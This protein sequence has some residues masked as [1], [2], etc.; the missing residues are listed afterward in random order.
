MQMTGAQ[1]LM[2]S[3]IDQGVEVVFGY[4][5][6]QAIIIFD[7]LYEMRD[8]IRHVLVS[9]EQGGAHTADGY[10]RSTGKPG[11]MIATSGPG[12]TNLVT[13]IA[14]AYHDSI[15]L[16]AITG[17]VPR[18][19]IGLTSFQEVD[20]VSITRPIVKRNYF[21]EDIAT[22][23]DTVREAFEIANSGR[24]GPVLIDVP[25]DITAMKA[26]YV[27]APR[28]SVRP[29][30]SPPEETIRR[31]ARQIA[32]AKR[33]VIYCGGGVTF[34]DSAEALTAFAEKI[35]APVCMSM[36]GLTSLP[37]G[38]P[39]NMGLVGMH[40]TLTANM[41]VGKCDLL[42]AVGARFSDR[43]AGNPSSFARGA[44]VIHIDIDKA[45][46]SKNVPVDIALVGHAGE[47][48]KRLTDLVPQVSRSP[49]LHEVL[50]HK[51]M[52]PLP[53]HPGAPDDVN[54][55]EV[56][57]ALR[58]IGG[59]DLI[60]ATDVGQH[61][62][63][64]AQYYP[65]ARPRSFLSS[66]GLGTMGYGMGAANGAAIG[67]PGRPVALVTGDGSFHMDMQ[68][69]A[70]TV[71]NNLPV[72]VVVM[73]NRVL[74]MVHQWQKLFF[75][76]RYSG[77]ELNSKTDFV[78]LAEAFGGTGM[79]IEK[80]KDIQ[81]VLQKAFSLNGPCVVEVVI[82]ANERVFPFIPP[83]ASTEEALFFEEFPDE[84]AH[85]AK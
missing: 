32:E 7:A 3:L 37:S 36:M 38:S 41:M 14:T 9:H 67:N 76:G 24:K 45:E 79:R 57:S 5:G 80:R 21:V 68:E 85:E 58:Q 19:S 13:G 42:L 74:G 69:F 77:T 15:P 75:G 30:T 65:F 17:N 62:M 71:T 4:P 50:Q 55:R 54:P 73:N 47:C 70:V 28:F 39:Y 46:I 52:N 34:S 25:K 29:A 48:L 78:K 61:Q 51:A 1:I 56:V 2:H 82:D 59:A 53:H 20:I 23:S 6:G 40:G 66:C 43:V 22:L 60:V 27:P 63:L 8:K 83:G 35:Q 11:V 44:T 49:W 31:A 81:P 64:V 12:A 84:N 72:V 33:P 18:A 26:E 10:Y 16:V